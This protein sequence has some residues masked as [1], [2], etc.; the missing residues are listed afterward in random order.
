LLFGVR[1]RVRLGL[2]VGGRLVFFLVRF[3]IPHFISQVIRIG[4][5]CVEQSA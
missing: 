5:K 4:T 2:G 3:F 1:A